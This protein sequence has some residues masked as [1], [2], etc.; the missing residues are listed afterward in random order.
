[1]LNESSI[2]DYLKTAEFNKSISIHV[3]DSVDSTNR[4]LKELPVA[5]TIEVCCAEAQ[6]HG[7][8]RFG[9]QWHSPYG[10]NIYLS[11]RRHFDCEFSQLSG[12]SIVVSLA[13]LATLN[14]MHIEDVRI[15]WPNDLIWNTKKLCG[16]LIEVIGESKTGVDV[17][18][19]IGLNVNSSMN[20]LASL[21][22][23]CCSL[24]EI[25]GTTFD[26]NT[27]IAKLIIQLEQHLH[28]F[29]T[30]G[31]TSFIETWNHADYLFG[32]FITVS[33]PTGYLN[34]KANGINEEGQLILIDE[35]GLSHFLSSGDTSLRRID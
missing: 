17:V 12:L 9:R 28:Q 30:K 33:Q 21:D 19:G 34:G 7:R 29:I 26:R 25:T 2:Q 14:H 8:G 32:Q 18:I 15:K 11:I 13:V 23:P 5:K 27:L 20:E 24:Y 6:T 4:F 10:Q 16:S 3:L 35:A 31:L 1:M 22:R